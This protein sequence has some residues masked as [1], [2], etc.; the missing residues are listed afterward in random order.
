MNAAAAAPQNE[1]PSP[2][3]QELLAKL[4]PLRDRLM[5]LTMRN[6]QLSYRDRGAQGMPL[7]PLDPQKLYTAL[8]E[9]DHTL[10]VEG[11]SMTAEEEKRWDEQCK[12]AE[13]LLMLGE[14]STPALE[15]RKLICAAT[16]KKTEARMN[17]LY[18]KYKE[19][20]EALGA[21]LCYMAVGFL[22]WSDRARGDEEMVYSP[23]ILVPVKLARQSVSNTGGRANGGARS[24]AFTVSHDGEDVVDNEALRLKLEQAPAAPILP[25]FEPEGEGEVVNDFF[26]KV[27]ALVKSLPR[28]IAAGWEVVR[29]ARIAFFNSSKGAMHR[30][31]DHTKWPGGT[32]LENEW[33]RAA[34]LG[35]GGCGG[36]NGHV[37]DEEVVRALHEDVVPTVTD[38]DSSQMRALVRAGRGE[39]LVIQGPPGT[40]KSQ[41]ITNLIAT[42]LHE[43]KS[44]LF[45][46][47]KMAA[48]SVVR[49]RLE[50][51]GLG[52]FCLEL[53]SAKAT[54][55]AVLAQVRRRLALK[56][57]TPGG[58]GRGADERRR[59]INRHRHKLES[60]GT[61]L[62]S[63]LPPHGVTLEAA[64]WA[65]GGLRE[66]LRRMANLNPD[67]V[68]VP[69]LR[70]PAPDADT[71]EQLLE[72]LRVA[73]ECVAD[74]VP[75]AAE[76]WQ[77]LE[78][79]H[80]PG[81]DM[82]EA[83][84]ELLREV[85]RDG[86]AWAAAEAG[87]PP[88]LQWREMTA[89][90]WLEMAAGPLLPEPDAL[91]Q[92]MV[93]EVRRNEDRRHD[94]R[95][96]L[97]AMR[98]WRAVEDTEARTLSQRLA[99]TD[100]QIMAAGEAALRLLRSPLAR[101]GF[102]THGEMDFRKQ[103]LDWLLET[104]EGRDAL[105]DQVASQ[106]GVGRGTRVT[107]GEELCDLVVRLGG[108]S[109][110]AWEAMHACLLRPGS[111][112]A[113]PRAVA[114]HS[115]LDGEHAALKA[116]LHVGSIPDNDAVS[117]LLEE[118]RRTA[119]GWFNWLPGT[120][121]HQV[122]RTLKGWAR[123]EG[124]FNAQAVATLL[125]GLCQWRREAE[126]FKHDKD[127]TQLLGPAF[128]GME[129]DWPAQQAARDTVN[130]LREKLGPAGAAAV[131]AG[132]DSLAMLLPETLANCGEARRYLAEALTMA[133][134]LL[135]EPEQRVS[136]YDTAYLAGQV[137]TFRDQ[138]ARDLALLAEIN[139][140]HHVPAGDLR[141]VCLTA[142]SLRAHVAVVDGLVAGGE[143]LGDLHQGM[144]A[145]DLEPLS[146]GLAYVEAV[147]DH[148]RLGPEAK[149]WLLDATPGEKVRRLHESIRSVA[150]AATTTGQRLA[151]L[152]AWFDVRPESVP[153]AVNFL[154]LTPARLREWAGKGQAGLGM[155]HP[156]YRLVRREREMR[157]LGA[158]AF[159]R[160]CKE[161][162]LSPDAA[163][164]AAR[165]SCW[166]Q[167]LR[168][169]E[170]VA[171]DL[172]DHHRQELEAHR[173]EFSRLDKLAATS[174]T[175]AIR[176]KVMQRREQVRPG[177]GTGSPKK[178]TELALIQ[179]ELNKTR[180]H[181]PV[182]KLVGQSH[183]ALQNLMPCWMLGP[184]AVAQFLPPGKVA[185]D[186]LVVDEASQVRPEDALG[187]LARAKQIVIVGDSK[188]MPPTDVFRTVGIDVEDDDDDEEAEEL[189]MNSAALQLES[190]LDVFSPQLGSQSL[191]WHYRSLHQSLIS[192]S[193][194]NF[195]DSRLVVPPSRWHDG[196][197]FGVKHH[198][199][200]HGILQ[201]RRNPAEAEFV[202][203]LMRTH[204]L[205]EWRKP[206]AARE[207]LGVVSMNSTQQELITDKWEQACKADA[208]LGDAC[209]QFEKPVPI[210]IRNLEN[211]QGDERDV[212][213]ASFT[214][215]PASAGGVVH[216]RFGPVNKVGGWRR[217][218]VL[219]TRAKKRFH[220][221]TSL[222][223]TDVHMD[224]N[225]DDRGKGHFRK[226]L[227]YAE[228]GHLPDTGTGK[229]R[230]TPD[231][232]FEIAV[233]RAIEALGFDIHYQVGVQ[234]FRIDIGVVHPESKGS[235]LCGIECDG[236]AY[237][238]HPISRDRDRIR[239][240]ILELRGWN[241][242]R[243]WSTDWYRNNRDQRNRLKEYL[244]GLM[245]QR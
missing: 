12:A 64:I 76:A 84:A 38:A 99:A 234:G 200:E 80:L 52:P 231:S 138:A 237:H 195:Y 203:Q 209:A 216:Q 65:Q 220:V 26:K 183:H 142:L 240:E 190:V 71:L 31:L 15:Q 73:A 188:Q 162:A 126:A 58:E 176:Q 47:E 25:E 63:V 223:H 24:Y 116:A 160:W 178:F 4:Q 21:N 158:E 66:D 159:W 35:G 144:S 210:F 67:E 88:P 104:L 102:T 187:S 170:R 36:G 8:V 37:S 59:Q 198:Y 141:D 232:P 93:A 212:I 214:Y 239:Q 30:D 215:G 40:G 39:S 218:N 166:T 221:V 86:E 233:G 213:V 60:Y 121:G 42:A 226:Y 57:G 173:A 61:T 192:F 147:L 9:E 28:E 3:R 110:S 44:V 55:K 75:A 201:N 77:G 156:W 6:R 22:K 182:R 79:K 194:E 155:L 150:D 106:L 186:L 164:C 70:N 174:G 191:E 90:H 5:D 146:E 50:K 207:T 133:S 205:K 193:N 10:K 45:M 229:V 152:Q 149:L 20:L 161:Q 132:R 34:V 128:A 49:E 145:T 111:D 69:E 27:E 82:T 219:F 179:H 91:P 68:R 136:G 51:A 16:N 122:R 140:S 204:V 105:L 56:T 206:V 171:P 243:I 107:D 32:L 97:E 41:S 29:T 236:A 224:L 208:E 148:P 154:E 108:L 177:V 19:C 114:R 33:L 1:L 72:A 169:C 23:L 134:T 117:S 151:G 74:G 46:S 62:R 211:V 225:G 139:L 137:R 157:E 119:G 167:V 92:A 127:F 87:V 129:T 189:N 165:F 109:P 43:G 48:L 245:N 181:V 118:V 53:H 143:F 197:D 185:F 180:S 54:P 11:L 163:V 184:Q 238:S 101:L 89:R 199:L 103:E 131:L 81:A 175:E 96:Y 7:C 112:A 168:E 100:E 115:E 227:Q 78:P 83:L 222:R 153:S 14:D 228:T 98:A 123:L 242:F 244:H 202:V 124:R 13:G 18:R 235:Y 2:E 17:G 135:N 196:E 172:L 85:E 241:I 113:L 120:K 130:L 230:N 125:E 94:Y 217:L 95:A